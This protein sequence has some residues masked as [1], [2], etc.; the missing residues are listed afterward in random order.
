MTIDLYAVEKGGK[1]SIAHD[2]NF[3]KPQYDSKHTITFKNPN[4]NLLAVLARSGPVPDDVNGARKK[5]GDAEKKKRKTGQVDMDKLAEGLTRLQEDDLL[6][7]IQ[8]IHDNKDDNTYTKN[9]IDRKSPFQLRSSSNRATAPPAASLQSPSP[10]PA[11]HAAS[12]PPPGGIGI[13]LF[14]KPVAPVLPLVPLRQHALSS[15]SPYDRMNIADDSDSD[16]EFHVDLYT[17][18]D[19]LIRMLWEFVTNRS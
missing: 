15:F 17:L 19:P 11:P 18:P 1:H 14:V 6:S 2:L 13:R 3:A 5:G 9:D 16:G 4:A 12:V 10:A 8:M 7:V